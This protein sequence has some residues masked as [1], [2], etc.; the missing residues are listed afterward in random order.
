MAVRA[1]PGGGG[2]QIARL[3][4]LLLPA[5]PR[6]CRPSPEGADGRQASRRGLGR[7]V[8][9][10]V[11]RSRVLV[12]SRSGGLGRVVEDVGHGCL[13]RSAASVASRTIAIGRR[14]CVII[15]ERSELGTGQP[16]LAARRE[17]TWQFL[18]PLAQRVDE[19][20]LVPPGALG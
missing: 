6:D 8:T 15:P 18:T 12:P 13:A 5:P 7:F 9:G 4:R 19:I 10:D 3:G 1:G 11:N 17:I 14:L 20:S 2:L 16:G